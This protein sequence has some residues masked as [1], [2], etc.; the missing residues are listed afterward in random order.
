[1]TNPWDR[2][3]LNPKERGVKKAYETLLGRSPD[4]VGWNYY[5]HESTFP[6]SVVERHI[7]QSD[8]YYKR[9]VA[10]RFSVGLGA[11]ADRPRQGQ[12][13]GDADYIEA[14]KVGGL[15][16]LKRTRN[17]VLDWLRDATTGGRWLTQGNRP[18]RSE[19]DDIN[20]FDRIE[21]AGSPNRD[22]SPLW[23]DLG[24]NPDAQRYF[25]HADLMA[26]R[27]LNYPDVQIKSVLDENLDWLRD[28]NLPKHLGGTMTGVYE[29]L[30]LTGGDTPVHDPYSP[31]SPEVT[32]TPSEYNVNI[33][34][35]IIDKPSRDSL[36]ITPG[37]AFVG[38]TA[39]GVS[40]A[41]RTRRRVR[42]TKDLAR[43]AHIPKLY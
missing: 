32:R 40:K 23:G 38:K 39:R 36:K 37:Q 2:D 15:S 41:K 3:D 17:E 25:G 42:E 20:L 6:L 9:N 14:L 13:F 5:V 8:E 29:S 7:R 18:G 33:T 35:D 12:Y 28:A 30:N 19:G 1:M 43:K 24:S 10:P 34:R 27:A 26:T 4:L 16:N 22:I 21:G 31:E 11:D